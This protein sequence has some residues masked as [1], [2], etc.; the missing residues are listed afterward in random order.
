MSAYSLVQ[1]F[2]NVY[3]SCT[4]EYYPV[5]QVNMVMC[6]VAAHADPSQEPDVR[7][8]GTRKG[9]VGLISGKGQVPGRIQEGYG[10]AMLTFATWNICYRRLLVYRGRDTL[11]RVSRN[12]AGGDWPRRIPTKDSHSG[13]VT[14]DS[15]S[16]TIHRAS[17]C[18]SGIFCRMHYHDC[19]P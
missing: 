6:R 4:S 8:L 12:K 18:S 15:S 2:V 3:S 7:H 16:K 17:L 9:A 13:S 5:R 10:G 14:V 11:I 1:V 19:P